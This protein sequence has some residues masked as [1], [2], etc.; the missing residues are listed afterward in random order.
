[1]KLK[2]KKIAT[3]FIIASLALGP[4]TSHAKI[5]NFFASTKD[6]LYQ[7]FG[8]IKKN[9]PIPQKSTNLAKKIAEKITVKN[10]LI[11]VGACA[12]IAAIILALKKFI[13]SYNYDGENPSPTMMK[14]KK[15]L[16]SQKEKDKMLFEHCKNG[17]LHGV[18][19]AIEIGADINAR[20]KQLFRFFRSTD[21]AKINRYCEILSRDGIE[22]ATIFFNKYST[23]SIEYHSPLETALRHGNEDVAEYLISKKDFK[24]RTIEEKNRCLIEA[25]KLGNKQIAAYLI[26]NGADVTHKNH[27]ALHKAC[28]FGRLEVIKLLVKRGVKI[29]NIDLEKNYPLDHPLFKA[30]K[31][32]HLHIIKFFLEEQKLDI[33]KVLCHV[34]WCYKTKNIVEKK[35]NSKIDEYLGKYKKQ[36]LFDACKKDKWATVVNLIDEG[37]DPNSTDE[38]GYA[39][40]DIALKNGTATT[41][42]VLMEKQAK[43]SDINKSLFEACIHGNDVKIVKYLEKNGANLHATIYPGGS[44][45]EMSTLD[46][47]LANQKYEIAEYLA[48]KNVKICRSIDLHLAK[49]K[50]LEN[51]N[52]TLFKHLE[53]NGLDITKK[54][55]FE[56]YCGLSILDA[57]FIEHD[58]R[59]YKIISY[60]ISKKVPIYG[61]KEDYLF[62]AVKNGRLKVVTYLVEN[63]ADVRAKNKNGESALDIFLKTC[64]PLTHTEK[65]DAAE[66]LIEKGA[67]IYKG[68]FHYTFHVFAHSL[69]N[70]F[71][72]LIKN[73]AETNQSMLQ[74]LRDASEWKKN[75][76]KPKEAKARKEMI[77][78]FQKLV[79]KNE[80]VMKL[81]KLI[82][83]KLPQ[84]PKRGMISVIYN[85]IQEIYKKTLNNHKIKCLLHQAFEGGLPPGERQVLFYDIF[86][87]HSYPGQCIMT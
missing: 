19:N 65:F 50:I 32:G 71:D 47:A 49:T 84:Y 18:K 40:F 11:T 38:N 68:L 87:R 62:A 25:C 20:K 59:S 1:M 24:I 22:A 55:E 76:L 2:R 67:L 10:S 17:N 45:L 7:I 29:H 13:S 86:K 3:C 69:T 43:P 77:Q 33:T 46:W 5:S 60:L 42:D 78:H 53:K 81:K 83:K 48:S 9:Q 64:L 8:V 74:V 79:E 30:C 35:F 21:N 66:Y 4:C 80:Q 31:N 26:K 27:K 15:L 82:S 73:G 54:L 39:L 70:V 41:L 57:A 37:I 61:N 34:P 72:H 23:S 12:G 52:I 44:Q 6:T 75:T 58:T 28:E 14:I 56:P 16:K 85:T 36:V 63:E 51:D